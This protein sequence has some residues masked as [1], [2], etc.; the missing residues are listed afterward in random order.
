MAELRAMCV[1]AGFAEI[2]TYIASGNVVFSSSSNAA[3]AKAAL[4]AQLHAYASKPVGVTLRTATELSAILKQNPFS[5]S[6][7]KH[8]YVI[9]LEKPPPSDA[10]DHVTGRAGE[11]MQ[12]SEREIFVAYPNGMG[13]SKLKI[14]AAKDGNGA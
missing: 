3:S 6:E 13:L 7:A 11:D 1:A 5:S 14:P 2:E 8:T 9:F 4:E 10:F 12:L